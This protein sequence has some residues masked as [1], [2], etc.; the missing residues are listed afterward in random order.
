[1]TLIQNITKDT[2]QDLVRAVVWDGGTPSEYPSGMTTPSSDWDFTGSGATVTDSR[3]VVNFLINET[4]SPDWVRDSNG[5]DIN[6]GEAGQPS[7]NSDNYFEA[8]DNTYYDMTSFTI[9]MVVTINLAKDIR[10][11]L[12]L[13]SGSSNNGNNNTVKMTLGHSNNIDMYTTQETNDTAMGEIAYGWGVGLNALHHNDGPAG[14]EHQY[15]PKIITNGVDNDERVDASLV[16]GTR[17]LLKW[18]HNRGD[19]YE[20]PD[21]S[22]QSASNSPSQLR[23]AVMGS[24]TYS[25][26]ANKLAGRG[27][28]NQNAS[29][30]LWSRTA[31]DRQLDVTYERILLYANQGIKS[32][33]HDTAVLSYLEGS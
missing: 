32:S 27:I 20:G 8:A 17:Y 1:M 29:W 7:Y 31:S 6:A 13:G 2:S 25:V 21:S 33:S 23:A 9:Y 22:Y 18:A 28:F 19:R 10:D 14:A 15:V 26:T 4:G 30:K 12:A 5:L 16:Q 24:G 11:F 3:G